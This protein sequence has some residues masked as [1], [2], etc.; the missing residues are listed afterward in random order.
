M[1][2]ANSAGCTWVLGKFKFRVIFVVSFVGLKR[3]SQDK[4]ER[5]RNRSK[6]VILFIVIIP[7]LWQV[8]KNS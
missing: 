8:N 1:G 6:K 2:L 5:S 3:L 4:K 7:S